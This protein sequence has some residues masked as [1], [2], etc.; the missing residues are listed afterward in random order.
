MTFVEKG[1]ADCQYEACRN[2][3]MTWVLCVCMPCAAVCAGMHSVR[4]SFDTDAQLEHSTNFLKLA[5]PLNYTAA[6][7]KSQVGTRGSIA[8]PLHY[9]RRKHVQCMTDSPLQP[10]GSSTRSH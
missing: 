10:P 3:M 7:K 8:H 4:L 6:V 2:H 1:G 9:P 5:H